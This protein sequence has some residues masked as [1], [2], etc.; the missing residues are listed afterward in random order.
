MHNCMCMF[1]G[2]FF[3]CVSLVWMKKFVSMSK[4]LLHV[5]FNDYCYL[6]SVFLCIYSKWCQALPHMVKSYCLNSEICQ[7]SKEHFG[8]R[9]DLLGAFR[10]KKVYMQS[11]LKDIVTGD[12]QA[13]SVLYNNF[14]LFQDCK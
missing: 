4:S 5:F 11:T 14:F 6:A 10:A 9:M 1:S 8:P 2:A 3:H 7:T 13:T 12:Y